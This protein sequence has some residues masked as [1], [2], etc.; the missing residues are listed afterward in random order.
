MPQTYL[1]NT[2]RARARGRP[3]ARNGRRIRRT[4]AFNG[5]GRRRLVPRT[6][7]LRI[8]RRARKMVD[9]IMKTNMA[10]KQNYVVSICDIAQVNSPPVAGSAN[11]PQQDLFGPLSFYFTTGTTFNG[12]NATTADAH[13]LL[14]IVDITAIS[15]IIRRDEAATAVASGVTGQQNFLGET[16]FYVED[17]YQNYQL[18][19]QSNSVI[20]LYMYYCEFRRDCVN[21]QSQ[22]NVTNLLYQGWTQRGLVI[23]SS[24]VSG[25]PSGDAPGDITPFDSH[26]FCSYVN[27]YKTEKVLMDPG[28]Q[29]NKTI[30]ASSKFI[31][32]DHYYT[33]TQLGPSLANES[34]SRDYSHRAG[35]KFILFRMLGQPTVRQTTSNGVAIGTNE[36]G[37][38]CPKIAMIT[39]THYTYQSISRQQPKITRGLPVGFYNP[40]QSNDNGFM[41][42]DESGIESGGVNA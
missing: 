36:G 3:A 11:S 12:G 17:C 8:K 10:N 4:R 18:T 19:S 22:Y 26:K 5:R 42:V 21:A 33:F 25:S 27:I 39:K 38:T 41:I 16:K 40:F 29:V 28:T 20:T 23:D 24:L 13:S 14:G 15:D 32:F 31:N 30:R 1:R 34:R 35:E 7:R 37:Y 2:R 6:R 9:T